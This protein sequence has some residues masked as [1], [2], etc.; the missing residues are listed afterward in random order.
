MVDPGACVGEALIAVG[1]EPS[2]DRRRHAM[3]A[4]VGER[5]IV[6]DIVG[7][8]GAQAF[9]KVQAA[10]RIG[11]AEPSEP[12]VADLGADRVAAPV[13]GAGVVDADPGRAR[14]TGT[15]D[16]A[17][18]VKEIIVIGVQKAHE[19]ALGDIDPHR[20]Q[21][22]EQAG[23]GDLSLMMKAE[24]EPAHL[25][26]EMAFDAGRQQS[27]QRAPVRRR[28]SFAAIAHHM[29]AHDQL[30]DDEIFITLE[31]RAGRRRLDLDDPIFVDRPIG[32]LG[33]AA[34]ARPVRG[35]FG[36]VRL[37]HPGR[38]AWRFDVRP[39]LQPLQPRYLTTQPNDG[40][41]QRR[42]AGH[43]LARQSFKLRFRQRIKINRAGHPDTESE[44]RTV[45][46][47]LRLP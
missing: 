30:L 24:R 7:V 46:N 28:P 47:R 36:T 11:R 13:A 38:S 20:V 21:L 42:H 17:R 39:A 41:T 19:L 2:E 12:I 34:P 23:D 3:F 45:G 6:D 10:L 18:L 5:L 4:H 22:P 15:Q 1:R 37:F 44:I 35:R 27:N 31:T 8:T 25:T 29:S 43:K 32:R 26:A 9:E 40:R 33:A 16:I 14:K